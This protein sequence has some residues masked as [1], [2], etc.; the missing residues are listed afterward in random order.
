MRDV[1]LDSRYVWIEGAPA[2]RVELL[3][4]QHGSSGDRSPPG[5]GMYDP[6]S[7]TRPW[8]DTQHEGFEPHPEALFYPL[9]VCAHAWGLQLGEPGRMF[10]DP[11]DTLS[12]NAAGTESRLGVGECPRPVPVRRFYKEGWSYDAAKDT[13][14]N[15]RV[16]TDLPTAAGRLRIT[17][18]G[19]FCTDTGVHDVR[20]RTATGTLALRDMLTVHVFEHDVDGDGQE[21]V[22]VTS[23]QG[24]NAWLRIFRL[25]K[26]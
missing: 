14:T 1:S 16:V 18:R 15:R 19:W 24:C 6:M 20:L 3:F 5:E 17:Y 13:S 10:I 25:S 2:V 26:R 23:S 11:P 4:D 9:T 12:I 21:E 7:N 8:D 22:F